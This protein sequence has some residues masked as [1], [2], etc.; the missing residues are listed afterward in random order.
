MAFQ[1]SPNV[2][3]QERDV[4]LF[5][6]QVSTTAGA[7]VGN[8]NWDPAE[9]FVTI[10]S[11]KTL[12]NTFGKPDSNS[13]KYWFVAANFL[14]YGNNLQVNRIVDSAARNAV[15]TGTA[16][17]VKNL[18]NYNGDLGYSAPTLTGTEYVA[19]YPG[20]RGNSIDRK[21]TRLNSSHTDISRMPSSA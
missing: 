10:D 8:F 2:L 18:S 13:Y 6:P 1:V 16:A 3:V 11:E 9:Q 21:S 7:F 5:I 12:Y 19:K 14:A 20:S 17:L 15:A 4:S